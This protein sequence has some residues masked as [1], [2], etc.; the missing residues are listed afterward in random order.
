[1]SCIRLD[2]ITIPQNVRRIGDE[3]FSLCRSLKKIECRAVQPPI[4]GTG[5]FSDMTIRTCSLYVPR[6]SVEAYMAANTWGE[7]YSILS[8]IKTPK[9]TVAEETG[10]FF[11][12][13]SRILAPQRGVNII[14]YSDGTARKVIV[15]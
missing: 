12:D 2:S 15:K 8:G 14:H 13:G 5:V 11:T 4:C 7:F 1:M 10:R 9:V 3:A 6:E